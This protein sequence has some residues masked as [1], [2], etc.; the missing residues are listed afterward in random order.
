M[1]EWVKVASL[2]DI[3]PQGLRVVVGDEEIL[4][5]RK[6]GEAFALSYL[7]SHLDME[8][9]GGRLEG[10]AWVCPHHGAK[11]DVRTGGTLSMPAVED[12]GSF[13]AKVEGGA[14]FLKEPA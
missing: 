12:V 5:V 7:C 2:D 6:G 9:E 3:P 4:V 10:D 11:F 1:G 13:E 8:L 14:V